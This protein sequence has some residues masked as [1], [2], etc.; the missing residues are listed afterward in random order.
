[1]KELIR[2]YIIGKAVRLIAGGPME[3]DW[4]IIKAVG[5]ML[6]KRVLMDSGLDN[7]IRRASASWRHILL[8]IKPSMFRANPVWIIVS[9]RCLWKLALIG[10]KARIWDRRRISEVWGVQTLPVQRSV[11]SW[12]SRLVLGRRII[13][14]VLHAFIKLGSWYTNGRLQG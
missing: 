3:L 14:V 2:R 7:W 10:A 6:G 8:L 11:A 5:W 1:M 9:M 12:V 4:T 13:P